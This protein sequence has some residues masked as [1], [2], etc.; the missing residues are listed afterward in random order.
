[1]GGPSWPFRHLPPHRPPRPPPRLHCSARPHSVRPCTLLLPVCSGLGCYDLIGRRDPYSHPALLVGR[2]VG[3]VGLTTSTLPQTPWQRAGCSTLLGSPS[4][5][6]AQ[7]AALPPLSQ[8]LFSGH[9]L[10][11]QPARQ[12]ISKRRELQ[13]EITRLQQASL[14]LEQAAQGARLVADAERQAAEA[15]HLAAEQAILR[16]DQAKLQADMQKQTFDS[17]TKNL[18]TQLAAAQ[19]MLNMRCVVGACC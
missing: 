14:L 10:G 6:G 2:L 19:G 16:A 1:M 8:Q 9:M 17:E 18:R 15:E 3:L 13:L 5:L 12:L 11:G 7:P 4:C